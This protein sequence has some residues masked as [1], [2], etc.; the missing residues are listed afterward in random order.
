MIFVVG[1]DLSVYNVALS[2]LILS[3]AKRSRNAKHER[4][5][6]DL[7]AVKAR[8]SLCPRSSSYCLRKSKGDSFV[9]I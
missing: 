4:E 6:S 9:Q 2:A 1:G 3:G 5:R 8:V 7:A